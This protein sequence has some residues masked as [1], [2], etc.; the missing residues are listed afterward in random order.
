MDKKSETL[1]NCGLI[2]V[3]EGRLMRSCL[4]DEENS[5][6][7]KK[8]RVRFSYRRYY[9]RENAL[10]VIRRIRSVVVIE[11]EG[12]HYTHTEERGIHC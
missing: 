4:M 6:R 11:Q 3:H 9:L 7:F 1:F 2:L 12:S 8:Y 10:Y 5:S